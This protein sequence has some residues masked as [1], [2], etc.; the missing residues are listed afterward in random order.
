MEP[1]ILEQLQLCVETA[2]RRAWG[3]RAVEGG[4]AGPDSRGSFLYLVSLL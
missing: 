4:T 2:P 3:P 1:N